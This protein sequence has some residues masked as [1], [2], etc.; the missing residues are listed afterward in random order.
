MVTRFRR[1]AQIA[2]VLVKYGFGIVVSEIFPG[3]HRFR[4]PGGSEGRD[5]RVYERIRLAIEELG[6]TFVKFGQIASTRQDLLPPPLI[7]ELRKLQDQ[8]RPLPFS[9]IR[10]VLLE[11][12]RD[13]AEY[14]TEIEET[15]V[16]SAS[17]SQVHRAVLKDGTK[18][19]LKIQRPGIEA[20]I[21]TD[22]AILQS[23]AVRIEAVFPESRI[24]NPKGMV[25]DFS[26]Q[27]RKELD[28]LRDGANADRLALNFRDIP[29]VRFPKIY[30]EYSTRHVL[31]ME[32]IEGVRV[33][34]TK[35][36]AGMGV[37]SVA[38]AKH[39]F[40]AYL[41][42]IFEDGFFHGDPHPGNL[43]ITRGGELVFLDFGII[44]VLRP[45]KKRLFMKLLEGLV[46]SDGRLVLTAL[47]GL[48]VSI[49]EEDK[50]EVRD[51]IYVALLD[52][53][54]IIIGRFNFGGMVDNLTEILRRYEIRIP[55]TLMLMLKVIVMVLDIGITLDPKFDFK[56]NVS[57]F[58]ENL[59]RKEYMPGKLAGR[60]AQAFLE[61]ADEMYDFPRNVNRMFKNFSTGTI[62]VEIVENE[63][64]KLQKS[65]DESSN[66]IL[67]GLITAAL[68]V[69]SSVVL[70][71]SNVVLPYWIFYLAI[72]GYAA[73]V[74]IGFYA[75]YHTLAY[76]L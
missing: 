1:Y 21:E 44:G 34:D 69:G 25:R 39:G 30:W 22:L 54:G 74:V 14:F 70:L 63:V 40:D 46:F 43:L 51:E 58:M 26:S 13:L 15:P 67:V 36:L 31:V 71:S 45:E 68:V 17:L 42:Q 76:H 50:D 32:F 35:A 24:Y 10:P 29:G 2:D 66:K 75:L 38:I 49:R 59:M 11:R 65:L 48:G 73:A 41:K 37:D 9:E 57:P 28:F 3:I 64:Q 19:A 33:D 7:E 61:T 56:A 5:R 60:A 12:N 20:I 47:E 4:I 27:I 55:V 62:K 6:P 53:E 23:L 16:A 52:A 72:L 8:V 18:V